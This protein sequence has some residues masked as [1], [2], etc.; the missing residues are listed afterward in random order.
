MTVNE[1]K[2][3]HGERY[4]VVFADGSIVKTTLNIVLDFHI[5][6]G[7]TLSDELYLQFISASSLA[8]AKMRSLNIIGARSMSEK[9]L[10]DRLV[11]KGETPE[12]AEACAEWC[13]SLGYL[14]DTKYGAMI[15]RHYAAKGYGAS[16]I[17]NEL[18]RRGVPRDL[19]EDSLLELPEQSGTVDKL[20]R[21]RLKGEV[22]QKSIKRASDAL[23]RRGFSWDEIKSA[24]NRYKS[25]LD[26]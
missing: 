20:L 18:Y 6:S 1:V 14:D 11:E 5:K 15:V 12:N 26:E 16:R 4:Y 7:D 25:E 24:L 13:V 19:W 23:M 2:Q 8:R 21:S 9:E 22:D 10:R 17:K 3:S